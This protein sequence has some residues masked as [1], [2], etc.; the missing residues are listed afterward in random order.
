MLKRLFQRGREAAAAG[1]SVNGLAPRM[2]AGVRVYCIGDI[3]GRLDLLQGIERQ[4]S[5]DA[6]A[7]GQGL[8]LIVVYLGDYVD[9]GFDSR[10]VID[11]L[12]NAP[13]PGFT[14]VYILG[15]HDIWMRSFA[16]GDDVA[17][18]WIR[19][20]GD[21]TLLSYGVKLDLQKP[22]PERFEEAQKGLQDRL[23]PAHDAFLHRLEL[24]FGLGDYFFC[25]AGIR[26][27]VPLDQQ[28][29]SDLCWIREPFLSWTGSAGKV[30]VHG[31]TVDERP[32]IRPN[33][34]G[35]DTGACWTNNLTCLVLEGESRRFLSTLQARQPSPRRE[36]A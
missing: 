8:E 23:P 4:N 31:H 1:P 9:R 13:L 29:E 33:R 21:A 28:S 30:I 6:A 34:I 10:R 36:L 12:L 24:A 3:H 19:F 20:G 11:H 18:S 7:S 26:P 16:R 25:H 17:E 5:A 35:I 15:N 22:E 32:V 14:P 27:D 2:P